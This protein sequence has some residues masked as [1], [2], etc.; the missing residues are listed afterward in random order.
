MRRLNEAAQAEMMLLKSQHGELV[1]A[2][3]VVDYARDE[4]TAL[5]AYFDWD[6]TEAARKW[7][8][9]QARAVIR[10]TVEV[11]SNDL[12][13]VRAFVSLTTDRLNG[14]GYRS[15]RDVLADDRLREVMLQDA[16]S[17]FKLFRKKYDGLKDLQRLWDAADAI[18]ATTTVKPDMQALAA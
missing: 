14:G 4:S 2:E 3:A 11:I 15:T 5:H 7:R 12:P 6:D 16:L 17:E 18:E 8:L 10:M 13:P 9:E 1:P